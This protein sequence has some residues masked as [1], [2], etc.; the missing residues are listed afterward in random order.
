MDSFINGTLRKSTSFNMFS[1]QA[2]IN[3]SR[4][5]GEW[6][7]EVLNPVY[8]YWATVRREKDLTPSTIS[9]LLHLPTY[10]GPLHKEDE[11]QRNLS[12][13]G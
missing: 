1:Q 7:V 12:T 13:C 10:E 2:R 9:L 6:I 8:G 11:R 3:R 4:H 5:T